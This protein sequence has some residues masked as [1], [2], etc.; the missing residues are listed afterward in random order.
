MYH[1]ESFK[2]IFILDGL[3]QEFIGNQDYKSKWSSII[4][5]NAGK[6]YSLIISNV[7]RISNLYFSCFSMFTWDIWHLDVYMRQ[8]ASHFINLMAETC[9]HHTKE[10]LVLFFFNGNYPCIGQIRY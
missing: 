1:N 5:L 8:L 10:Q 4:P 9:T 2:N 3:F 7:Y 6:K